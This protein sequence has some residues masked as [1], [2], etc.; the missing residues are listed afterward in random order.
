MTF[1]QPLAP[2]DYEAMMG[3]WPPSIDPVKY[4]AQNRAECRKAISLATVRK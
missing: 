2:T 4:N 3:V 1:P